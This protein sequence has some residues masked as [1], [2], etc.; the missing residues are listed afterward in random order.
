MR[1]EE[2]FSKPF[3]CFKVPLSHCL[4]L[5]NAAAIFSYQGPDT[6]NIMTASCPPST[7][8]NSTVHVFPKVLRLRLSQATCCGIHPIHWCPSRDRP[9]IAQILFNL[10]AL[11]VFFQSKLSRFNMIEPVFDFFDE[12][13][14][15]PESLFEGTKKAA[16]SHCCRHFPSWG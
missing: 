3:G 13:A 16:H 4:V 9:M 2:M 10:H 5:R 14:S 11:C 12:F 8:F 7:G 1:C 15:L 6:N